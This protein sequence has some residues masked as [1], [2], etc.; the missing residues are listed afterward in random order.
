LPRKFLDHLEQVF[1]SDNR[2]QNATVYMEPPD[3]F[4]GEESGGEDIDIQNLPARQLRTR[5]KV[6]VQIFMGDDD[7]AE[8]D[9]EPENVMPN[10]KKAPPFKTKWVDRIQLSKK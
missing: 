1:D 2:A 4:S 5:A 3:D 9:D 6:A 8:E 7:S 10:R